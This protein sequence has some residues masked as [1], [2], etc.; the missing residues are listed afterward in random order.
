MIMGKTQQEHP[1]RNCLAG[2]RSEPEEWAG[3]GT[4]KALL[5]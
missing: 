2:G 1:E 4:K 5:S 3:V